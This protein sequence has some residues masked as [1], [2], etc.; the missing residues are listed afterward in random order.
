MFRFV[1]ELLGAV[2]LTFTLINPAFGDAEP[3][4]GLWVEAEGTNASFDSEKDVRTLLDYTAELPISDLYCQVYRN[5][6]S[7]FPSMM[8]DDAPYRNALKNGVDPLDKIISE[9]HARGQKVH[10]WFNVLRIIS[11]KD[12]PLI[13]TIGPEAVLK[14]SAGNS[15][16]SYNQRGVGPGRLGKYFQLGTQ[17]YWL[18]SGSARVRQYIVETIRDLVIAYPNIDGVHLDMVRFPISMR[19]KGKSGGGKRPSFGFSEES[20]GRFFEFTGREKPEMTPNMIEKLRHSKSWKTWK[21]AQVTLLVFQIKEML[22]QVAPHLELSAAVVASPHRSYNEAYQDWGEWVRGGLLQTVLPMSY[23][24]DTKLVR[25][26]S[27]HA[28]NVAK[29]GQVIIGLGAW[30]MKRNT[31][32]LVQQGKTVMQQK[33]DGVTLFSYSNL[34]GTAG[35]KTVSDFGRLVF[36]MLK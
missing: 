2:F 21:R 1:K 31:P 13:K 20:L 5:G 12:A 23:T 36:P 22:N 24:T 25:E 28:R 33:A 27:A 7:W 18:E 16:L 17:G 30:L 14:D 3:R 34:Y 9:A 4:F 8:A 32:L 6:R 29:D 15:L 35:K 10:A 19:Q 26:Y 11:N